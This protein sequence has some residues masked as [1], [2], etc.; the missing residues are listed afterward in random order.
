MIAHHGIEKH[1]T[2]TKCIDTKL[3]GSNKAPD[4]SE[5]YE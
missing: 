1:R 5:M 4:V 3:A 2:N